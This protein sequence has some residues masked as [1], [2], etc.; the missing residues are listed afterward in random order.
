MLKV[1]LQNL[2]KLFIAYN[3]KTSFLET[4]FLMAKIENDVN[5]NNY[6]CERFRI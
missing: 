2:N 4:S 1:V 5:K 6:N 3:F